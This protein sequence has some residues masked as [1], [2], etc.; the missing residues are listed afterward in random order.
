MAAAGPLNKLVLA[1]SLLIFLA[2][3]ASEEKKSTQQK[4]KKP[5]E[6]INVPAF[7]A[8][9]AYK[10]IEKQVA[11]GPRVPGTAAHK[12]CGD[13]LVSYFSA[14]ADT[15]LEQTGEVKRFDGK[16]MPMRNIIASFKPEQSNRIV[17]A[18]HWDTRF[19]SDQEAGVDQAIDGAN[20]GG[21]G[22]AVLMEMARLFAAQQPKLGIDIILF[23]VEDQGKPEDVDIVETT[24]SWCLGSQ[25]W[26]QNPHKPNYY[27]KYG[28]LLDMVAGENALFTMEGV[29]RQKAPMLLSQVW[30]MAENL[31]YGN[32]FSRQMTQ[33]IL[34]DHVFMNYYAGI[35]TI[36]IIEYNPATQSHFYEHWHTTA[37][38]MDNISKETLK[39][40][41]HT[42]T[43]FVYRGK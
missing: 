2:G 41:G 8:D 13:Y 33:E 1:L 30:T 17:L 10:F 24:T 25:Y 40:V 32:Y 26:S 14:Y 7:S 3:C 21:S 4:P 39:A 20:D 22:V 19:T 42:L 18:A 28:I 12:A 29:S 36:D 16:P 6:K 38:N 31:G 11:F 15:V 37:D 43:E 34:D 27:A 5:V 35:P 9:S 23:D